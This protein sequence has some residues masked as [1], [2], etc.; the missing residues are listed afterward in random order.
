MISS[1]FQ[2]DALSFDNQTATGTTRLQRRPSNQAIVLREAQNH[3]AVAKKISLEVRPSQVD[4]SRA[5]AECRILT[6]APYDRYSC[7]D[8]V[9]SL[10][11]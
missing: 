8:G 9:G 3:G 4:E 2:S 1:Q 11:H 6:T 5:S 7:N 10:F